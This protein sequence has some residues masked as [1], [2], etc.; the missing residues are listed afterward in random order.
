MP[1]L[2]AESL[3]A[4]LQWLDPCPD[5]AGERYRN[6]Q[7][8]LIRLFSF[9]G[10]DCPEELA[11]EVMDRVAARVLRDGP[12]VPSAQHIRW[13]YGVAK[14]VFLEFTR[15][16]KSKPFSDWI[17]R[18]FSTH[19]IHSEGLEQADRCLACCLSKL[20]D[21]ERALLLQYYDFPLQGKASHRS[22]MAREL[23]V[24]LN[25]LRVRM[26]RQRASLGACFLRCMGEGRWPQ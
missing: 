22:R 17:Y 26:C 4:L 16:P 6:V 24:P 15:R 19:S 9:K 14:R 2:S 11:D 21:N 20:D 18:S 8:K 23:H 13:F 5:T 10:A 12:P 7:R 25:T 1:K 3:E